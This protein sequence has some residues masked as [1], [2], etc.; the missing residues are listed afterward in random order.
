MAKVS[1][2]PKT[3]AN[4][5]PTKPITP[6]VVREVLQKHKAGVVPSALLKETADLWNEFEAADGQKKK[7]LEVKLNDKLGQ[8]SAILHL[9]NHYLFAETVNEN[10]NRTLMIEMI[11]QLIAEYDCNTA[12]EKMLAQT[13][14]WAYCRMIEYSYKLNGVTRQEFI[15]HEKNGLY[16]LLSKE[17]DRATRQYLMAINT[18]K[19]FKQPPLNVT[20]KTNN[21]F[22]AQNQQIN[23]STKEPPAKEKSNA[24]Q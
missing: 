6:E 12:T 21:A 5:Q 13:A 8:A 3:K 18:L 22:V 17:V 10:K 23:S 4:I 11:N 19:H 7:A 9:D 15:S 24:G 2:A 20:L 1:N 16:S 14:G